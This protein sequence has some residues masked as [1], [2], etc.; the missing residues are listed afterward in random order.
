MAKK[1]YQALRL[2]AIGPHFVATA[3]I[4]LLLGKYVLD[5]WLGTWPFFTVALIILGFVA[6]F[7]HLL[8]ELNALEKIHEDPPTDT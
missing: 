5:P 4:G 1:A 7:W 8:R 6:S 2:V 3:V